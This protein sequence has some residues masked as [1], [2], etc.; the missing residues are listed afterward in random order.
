MVEHVHARY[1]YRAAWLIFPLLAVG[2][3]A[4]PIIAVFVDAAPWWMETLFLLIAIPLGWWH[5]ATRMIYGMDLTGTELVLRAPLVRRRIPLAE[6]AEFGLPVDQG[7]IR[8][9][10]AGRP[11]VGRPVRQR[12]AGVHRRGRPGRSARRGSDGRLASPPG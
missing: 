1:R 7:A 8:V 10:P 5:A 9:T 3:I 11:I 2:S 4:L 12:C 6:L